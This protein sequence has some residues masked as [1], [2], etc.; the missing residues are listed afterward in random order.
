MNKTISESGLELIIKFE[1]LILKP[2]KDPNGMIAIGYGNTYYDD[3]TQVTKKDPAIS[4][5]RAV[6]LLKFTLKT[7][8]KYV[9]TAC[10]D[11]INQNQ[12]DALVSLCYDIGI[13]NFR[14]SKLLLLMNKNP[15]DPQLIN[16]FN[17]L[18]KA[19]SYVAARQT[20]R[21]QLEHQLYFS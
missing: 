9:N 5:E 13:N 2:Y 6:E 3:D 11:D 19:N 4:P 18:N 15:N 20:Y 10:R 14:N 17:K 7:Y 12:F 16:E 21:R 8:E 1:D